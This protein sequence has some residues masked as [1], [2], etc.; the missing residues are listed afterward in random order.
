MCGLPSHAS[1]TSLSLAPLPYVAKIGSRS[2]RSVT[3]AAPLVAQRSS[4]LVGALHGTGVAGPVSV[5]TFGPPSAETGTDGGGTVVRVEVVVREVEDVVDELVDACF[6]VV[7]DTP[8]GGPPGLLLH[9][10]STGSATII[11]IDPTRG[12]RTQRS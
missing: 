2:M 5:T 12:R 11:A 8:D 3:L 1:G 4:T 6:T 10:L 9:A 7:V